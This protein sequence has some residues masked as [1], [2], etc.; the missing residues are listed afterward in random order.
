MIS[1][2]FDLKK[3]LIRYKNLSVLPETC[4]SEKSKQHSF[5][6]HYNNNTSKHFKLRKLHHIELSW[7]KCKKLHNVL[8]LVFT[9]LFNIF[10]KDFIF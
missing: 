4:L 1:D 6:I 5:I 7:N 9:L 10:E 8:C 2:D 3:L